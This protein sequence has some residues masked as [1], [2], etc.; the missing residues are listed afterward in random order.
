MEPPLVVD[1]LRTA[2]VDLSANFSPRAKALGAYYTAAQVAEFLVWWAVRTPCDKILDP[3]F[4][5]GVFLRSA[6]NRLSRLGGNPVNQIFGVELDNNVH[7][8]I[9]QKL[10][11][12]VGVAKE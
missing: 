6:C 3:S 11:E 2:E 8:S 10:F 9:S 4:G 5:S 7:A 1:S 12:E